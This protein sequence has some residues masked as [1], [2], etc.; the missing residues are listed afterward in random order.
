MNAGT[1]CSRGEKVAK[2]TGIEKLRPRVWIWL[3]IQSHR[4][5]E[6]QIFKKF[7]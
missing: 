6:N 1:I 3:E 5:S 4:G 2:A 7:S